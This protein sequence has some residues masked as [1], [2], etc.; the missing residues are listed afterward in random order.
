MDAQKHRDRDV[1][2]DED[3]SQWY[4]RGLPIRK[5]LLGAAVHFVVLFVMLLAAYFALEYFFGFMGDHR[6]NLVG[7]LADAAARS[8]L[9]SACFVL[10]RPLQC[11]LQHWI[12][13]DQQQQR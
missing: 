12:R 11:R 9:L 10:G 2:S 5:R 8:A 13:G 1:G 6:G 7:S 3:L 4:R